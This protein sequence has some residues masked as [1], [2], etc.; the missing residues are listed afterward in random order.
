MR[1]KGVGKRPFPVSNPA[2]IRRRIGDESGVTDTL[3]GIGMIFSANGQMDQAISAYNEA[4]ELQKPMGQS[5]KIAITIEHLGT[6]HE[7]QG[8]YA[9]ALSKYRE[10]LA[11]FQQYSHAADVADTQRNIARVQGKMQGAG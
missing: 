3:V 2:Y 4:L 11:L 1:R 10:A 7:R 5:V 6:V 9:A 8:E